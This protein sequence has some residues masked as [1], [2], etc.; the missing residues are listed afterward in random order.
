MRNHTRIF[1]LLITAL[2]LAGCGGGAT[3]G[4]PL[5]TDSILVEA[6][7]TSVGAGQESVITATVARFNE[8][9]AIERSVTFTF[10]TNNS[11]GTLRVVNSRV[12]GQ[13][14][15]RAVY[16]AGWNAPGV[17]LPDTIQASL[18][19][20]AGAVVVVTRSGN[21][22]S[23]MKADPAEVA[24]NQSSVV[25]VSV[26]DSNDKPIS[27]ATVFF[28]ITVNNS[29]APALTAHSGVT[30]GL[31]IVTTVYT[32]GNASPDQTVSDTVEARL[33]NGSSRS[34][35]ITR[36]GETVEPVEPLAI[37]VAADPTSVSAG[38][39]SIITATLTGDNK[40][41]VRVSFALPINNSGASL[42]ATTAITDGSGNAVVTYRAGSNNPT[43]AVQDTVR[44]VVGSIS[45][46]AVITRTGSSSAAGYS[47]TVSANPS[48]LTTDTSNSAIT[49]NVKDSGGTGV[50]G[51]QVTFATT[52]TAPLGTISPAAAVTDGSGNAVTTFTGGG[53]HATG[54][55]NVVTASIAISGNT[56][57][58]AV[59]IT[60]P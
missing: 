27:G 23:E 12:D 60:Y 33:A 35:V 9:P 54:D 55:T 22:I 14:Q 29:G 38:G 5:A 32:P 31:G 57:T 4:D 3:S 6:S 45:S 8:N 7:P 30:D 17:E 2:V 34:V 28:S 58:A 24:A 11:G 46:S 48:T 15:A 36:K 19:T 50:S 10:R 26:T 44:A 56:Y 39:L 49:A 43:V 18:P 59:V 16:T 52:G 25:T 42:S 20:G 40:N 1:L 51:V 37:S 21:G 41:G 47:I 13:N 53:A